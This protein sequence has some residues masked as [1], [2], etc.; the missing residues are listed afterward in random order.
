MTTGLFSRLIGKS[1]VVAR[2]VIGKSAHALKTVIGKVQHI[3]RW[4]E[5]HVPEVVTEGAES[6]VVHSG[7]GQLLALK[8]ALKTTLKVAKQIADWGEKVGRG[9][10]PP[11]P[12]FN[13]YT[14]LGHALAHAQTLV[15]KT[16]GTKRPR[17]QALSILSKEVVSQPHKRRRT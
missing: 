9:P 4:V 5:D 6:A 13:A 11:Q 1:P 7:Y 10:R 14:N 17:D 16:R 12:T 2:K 15:P 8:P 3:Q